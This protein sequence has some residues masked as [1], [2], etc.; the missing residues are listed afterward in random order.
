M[1]LGIERPSLLWFWGPNSIMVVY[2]DPLGNR[3]IYGFGVSGLSP[4]TLS[5]KPL[6]SVAQAAVQA[7]SMGRGVEC[8][9]LHR[10]FGF[11]M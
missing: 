5:L 4:D 11:R 2:M 7:Q 6:H 3:V 9:G 8:C 10:G 1:E